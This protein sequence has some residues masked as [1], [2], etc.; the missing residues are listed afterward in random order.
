VGPV[1]PCRDGNR[2]YEIKRGVAPV[3]PDIVKN[4]ENNKTRSKK[5]SKKL[6][7]KR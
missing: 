4:T 1:D 6:R 7:L 3:C 2:F 5:P